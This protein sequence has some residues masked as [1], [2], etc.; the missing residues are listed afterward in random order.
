MCSQGV[1]KLKISL[2]EIF[3]NLMCL[4]LMKIYDKT[5]A[6]VTSAVFNTRQHVDST[7]VF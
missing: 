6:M 2:T 4:R 5:A 3:S 7:R 1:L